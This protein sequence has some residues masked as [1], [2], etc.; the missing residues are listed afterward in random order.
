MLIGQT[1]FIPSAGSPGVTYFGP[2]MPR[3]G[4]AVTAVIEALKASHPTL[5]S[6]K[7]ELQ[8]KNNEDS[9]PVY[10]AG[11]LGSVTVGPTTPSTLSSPLTGCK[12]LVRFIFSG[13]GGGGG[14]RWVHFRANP[15][16]WQPN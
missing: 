1:I 3:Q 7:C 10:P 8:T 4:N 16:I 9:D 5:W 14:D 13:T 11:V 15:L 2:W 12:E 6:L